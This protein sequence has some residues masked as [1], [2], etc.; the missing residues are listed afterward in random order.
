MTAETVHKLKAA[1][2]FAASVLTSLGLTVLVG[3]PWGSFCTHLATAI[4]CG[5][6]ITG[7]VVKATGV[8]EQDSDK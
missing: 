8:L 1:A 3:T 4:G 5:I 7:P 2:W 6:G